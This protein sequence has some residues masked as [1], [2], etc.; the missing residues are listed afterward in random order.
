MTD[1]IVLT[2][3]PTNWATV[4]LMGGVFL[5]LVFAITQIVR[6]FAVRKTE[7]T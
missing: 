6:R 7:A 3:S 5:L 1:E 4:I 2:W